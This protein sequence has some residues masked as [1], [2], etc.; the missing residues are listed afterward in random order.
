MRLTRLTIIVLAALGCLTFGG[1]STTAFGQSVEESYDATRKAYDQTLNQLEQCDENFYEFQQ[2]FKRNRPATD[3]PK[4]EWDRWA[5]SYKEWMG[6]MTG[7][8]RKLKANADVLKKK[9]EDL[10]KALDAIEAD[11]EEKQPPAKDAKD[12]HEKEKELLK[13]GATDL[14][15]WKIGLKVRVGQIHQMCGEASAEV[16]KHGSG[17]VK[18]EPYFKYDF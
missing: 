8:M 9:L 1:G 11:E 3:A 6:M 16:E 15:K 14:E 17:K 7:C 13:K 12:K 10:A 18:I 4:E 2:M 5:K